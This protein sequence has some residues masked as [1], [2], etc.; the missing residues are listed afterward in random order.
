MSGDVIG[1]EIDLHIAAGRGLVAK[2][3]GGFLGMGKAK[4]SDPYVAVKV[5]GKVHAKT[6]HVQKTLDP[7]WNE[8]RA[9][10]FEGSFP[11]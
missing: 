1:I 2:D 5:G 3:G 8:V 10:G 11:L 6:N 7:V 9:V 4:T